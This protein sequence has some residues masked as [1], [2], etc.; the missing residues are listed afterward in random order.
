MLDDTQIVA[1]RALARHRSFREAAQALGVSAASFSR[2][3]AAAEQ[4]AGQPLFDRQRSGARPTV[5][6]VR[7]LRLLEDVE[8]A[9]K[10]FDQAVA[11]LRDDDTG[12]LRIGCG[13]LTTRTLITPALTRVMAQMPGLRARVVVRAT[14]DPLDQLRAEDLDVV[15]CDLTH[16]PALDDLDIHVMAREPVTFWARAGHPIFD[17]RG[18]AVADLLRRP[19]CTAFLHRH[20]RET[21]FQVLGADDEARHIVDRLPQIESCDFGFLSDLTQNSDLLCAGRADAFREPAALGLMCQVQTRDA[22]LWN[23]C[24]A[25]R[26]GARGGALDLFWQEMTGAS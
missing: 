17:E 13:P 21:V 26:K 8:A 4:R 24:A 22:L 3:I 12:L 25:K 5:F 19:F 6:G 18:L 9:H 14:S 2:Q 10:Q 15:V 16:T 20:W 7:Y 1:V 11:Q 23:I